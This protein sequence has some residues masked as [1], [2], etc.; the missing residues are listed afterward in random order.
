MGMKTNKNFV[1]LNLVA[2]TSHLVPHTVAVPKVDVV[3]V[4][5]W[6]LYE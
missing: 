2:N 3:E 4:V 1:H 6:A 5:Q